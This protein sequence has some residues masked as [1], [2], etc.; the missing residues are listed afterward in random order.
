MCRFDRYVAYRAFVI[1]KFYAFYKVV[2]NGFSVTGK[3]SH[4]I[5]GQCLEF[6]NLECG[7]KV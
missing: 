5:K 2:V 1:S 7:K 4:L 3:E 6:P